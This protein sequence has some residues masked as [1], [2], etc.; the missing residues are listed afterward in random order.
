MND[1]LAI[2]LIKRLNKNSFVQSL[3][4]LIS[5]I[6]KSIAPKKP[7]PPSYCI[8]DQVSYRI[9]ESFS[10]VLLTVV[11][12]SYC[13]HYWR[14]YLCRMRGIITFDMVCVISA[15]DGIHYF[16]VD[17]DSGSSPE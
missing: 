5:G 6:G 13:G 12:N 1:M 14:G 3:Q 16:Q 11:Y 17:V 4:F 2:K 15:K 10:I 7:A 8:N 9:F